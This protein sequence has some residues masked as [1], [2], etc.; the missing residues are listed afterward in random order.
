[1]GQMFGVL[2]VD[3]EEPPL[4]GHTRKREKGQSPVMPVGLF[5]VE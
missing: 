4:I 1:M 2:K 5:A 3:E